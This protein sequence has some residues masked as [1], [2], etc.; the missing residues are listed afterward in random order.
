MKIDDL[1]GTH[2]QLEA[3][4]IQ[5]SQGLYYSKVDYECAR[6]SSYL[7]SGVYNSKSIIIFS[8]GSPRDH[9]TTDKTSIV[10][11]T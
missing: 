7:P 3:V 8:L 5:V 4:V 2:N 1:H 11:W 9:L 6:A 10:R